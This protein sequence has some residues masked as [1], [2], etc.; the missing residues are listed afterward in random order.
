MLV[1]PG[2]LSVNDAALAASH[3]LRLDSDS[4]SRIVVENATVKGNE[5]TVLFWT[6]P[7]LGDPNSGKECPLNFYSVTLRPGLKSVQ[8]DTVAREVCSGI[9]AKGGVLD[10][11][12]GLIIARTPP[13]ATIP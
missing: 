6:W 4:N 9:V 12:D 7:D 2:L 11:G 8:A 5:T 1:L 10:D 3:T 13:L